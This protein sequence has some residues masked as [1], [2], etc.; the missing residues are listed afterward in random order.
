MILALD[1][2]N[3]YTAG[4]VLSANIGEHGGRDLMDHWYLPNAEAIE[5]ITAYPYCDH[6]AIEMI[7]CYGMAV[8][9]EVFETCVWIGRFIER[10]K[11]PC[12]QIYRRDVK[13]HLCNSAKAKDGNVRQA[14]LDLYGGKGATK[15][16][17]MLHGVSGDQWA[18]LGVGTTYL[19]RRELPVVELRDEGEG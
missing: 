15:K 18:A 4:V 13:L 2:G 10:W 17:G 1:P 9:R 8:G 16:G 6:L 3:T 19:A 11:G 14:L 5:K 12:T 7:A